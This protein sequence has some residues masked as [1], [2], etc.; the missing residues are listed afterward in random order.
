MGELANDLTPQPKARRASRKNAKVP[1]AK[2]LEEVEQLGAMAAVGGNAQVGG[3]SGEGGESLTVYGGSGSSGK[4]VKKK[5]S[6]RE[7]LLRQLA[8]LE[9]GVYESVLGHVRTFASRFHILRGGTRGTATK[10]KSK[11]TRLM[12]DIETAL[13]EHVGNTAGGVNA[14]VNM[15]ALEE[16]M[17][18]DL[19]AEDVETA[20]SLRS[21]SLYSAVTDSLKELSE[22]NKARLA[23]LKPAVPSWQPA[24][25]LTSNAPHTP[26]AF[27]EYEQPLTPW[28]QDGAAL[29]DLDTALIVTPLRKSAPYKFVLVSI[30]ATATEADIRTA[31]LEACDKETV[32]I[33]GVEIFTD[34]VANKQRR[35]AF[36]AVQSLAQL[37]TV[38]HDRVRA[39]GVHINGQRSSIVDVEE[40][41]LISVMMRPPMD[42]TRIEELLKDLGIMNLVTKDSAAPT[43]PIISSTGLQRA[44]PNRFSI[45]APRDG[46]GDLIGKAWIS[47]P[48]HASAFAAYHSLIACRPGAIRAFWSQKSPN[49]FEE[50]IRLRDALAVENAELKQKVLSLTNSSSDASPSPEDAPNDGLS[51][52]TIVL[53]HIQK[54]LHTTR[55]DLSQAA[56]ILNISEKTLQNHVK[57]GK[58]NGFDFPVSDSRGKSRLTSSRE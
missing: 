28:D 54:V 52:D 30:D 46:N 11:L 13:K 58:T 10:T 4:V 16:A 26:N 49:H 57:K 47:F 56:S 22:S 27:I 43:E 7:K 2:K 55:G 17:A 39:F 8:D 15:A 3:A 40:K 18:S 44:R 50:A 19:T 51:L 29:P 33:T 14:V 1:M 20:R 12:G 37:Q 35:H 23:P 36:V 32:E 34:L 6:A 45:F 41:N 5:M 9:E 25:T 21:T 42:A 48:N 24:A 31:V 53:R 38:L